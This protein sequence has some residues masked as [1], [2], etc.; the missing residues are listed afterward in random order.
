[1]TWFPTID[2]IN[3]LF[4]EWIDPPIL[5]NSA[6]LES[7]LDKVKWGL[8]MH[9]MPS[10]WDSAA[11]LYLDIVEQHFFSDGNKRIG[12]LLLFVFLVKNGFAFNPPVGEIFETTME[13]AM[14]NKKFDA[15][16]QWIKKNCQNSE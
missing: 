6:G 13:I 9:D 12:S 16:V 15:I 4:K 3:E 8:P 14:G 1:M 10:I 7:T 2:Y 11:I 5:M